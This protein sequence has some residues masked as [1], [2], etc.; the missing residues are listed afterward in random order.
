MTSLVNRLYE[1]A[2]WLEDDL[3]AGVVAPAILEGDVRLDE[4][5]AHCV[6]L[7]REAAAAL[8]ANS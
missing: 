3:P 8:E 5:D 1:A 6:M 7:M 4:L 2:L